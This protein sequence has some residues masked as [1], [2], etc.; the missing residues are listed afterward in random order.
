ML[1]FLHS[2][3]NGKII[4]VYFMMMGIGTELVADEYVLVLL[5]FV[6]N[7]FGNE[8]GYNTNKIGNSRKMYKK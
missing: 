6:I 3:K 5:P 8:F 7:K 1:L 2:N 4:L